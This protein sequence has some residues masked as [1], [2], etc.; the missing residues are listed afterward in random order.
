[1]CLTL[2]RLSSARL[3]LVR[4]FCRTP[5]EF[6]CWYSSSSS[7]RTRRSQMVNWRD[8]VGNIPRLRYEAEPCLSPRGL[9]AKGR[10]FCGGD[11]ND[12]RSEPLSNAA[13]PRCNLSSLNEWE[14]IPCR[15]YDLLAR[16]TQPNGMVLRYGWLCCYPKSRRKQRPAGEPA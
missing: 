3:V 8:W 9:W 13:R 6:V 4:T 14:T 15:R 7:T 2:H 10:S 11:V 5:S 12:S 1:M 16:Q